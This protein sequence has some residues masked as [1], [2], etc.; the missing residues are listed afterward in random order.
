MP[1]LLDDI[2]TDFSRGMDDSRAATAFP[3]DAAKSIVNGRV[4]PDGTVG[5]RWG[6]RRLHTAALEDGIGYGGITF[7]TDAGVTQEIDIFG[8]KA[9]MSD[10]GWVTETEIASGL[11]EDYYTFTTMSVGGVTYLYLANGD[12]TIKRWDGSTWDTLP[13]VPE[14]VK[15]VETFNSR[16]Y[17]AGHSGVIVQASKVSDPEVW[18]TSLGAL[19]VQVQTHGGDA[20]TGIFQLG[21]YLIV[22]DEDATSYIDGF[23]EQTIV[24]AAGA[25][26]MSRSVG[27]IAHRT[28]QAIGDRGVCWLSKR[29]VE[30]LV[31]GS[32][33]R[34]LTRNMQTFMA[35]VAREQIAV[36]RGRPT[37]VYD[38]VTQDYVL[39][40]STTG[41][42][43]NRAV[44][45]N[46]LKEGRDWIGSPSTDRY[47]DAD[48]DI[49]L[50]GGAD[51]YLETSPTGSPTKADANGYMVL[52][53][54]GDAADALTEEDG[55]LAL[56]T[57]DTVPAT[58]YIAPDSVRGTA[59]HSLG[60]DGFVRKHFDA[61]ADDEIE[62]GTGGTPVT[63]TLVPRPFLF[64]RPRNKKRARIVHVA[65]I[66]EDPATI[67]VAIRAD[68]ELGAARSITIPGTSS[69]Q[70]KRRRA[71]VHGIDDAPE[72][73]LTTTDRTR[74]SLVGLS[75]EVMK[76]P[77]Q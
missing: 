54:A 42:R 41:N 59:I 38:H 5:R 73:V 47:L 61:D 11:R 6:S 27:C 20:I 65:A 33:I 25:T 52:A 70:A 74:I 12:T 45:V 28:I 60:Y 34:L 75:A 17:V 36:N 66:N 8:A 40:L 21:S 58:L 77:D 69:N 29:G 46:M 23:G 3:Q 7:Q 4:E 43:N 76:E 48:G 62:D 31:S 30:Y 24:V 13:N 16:L 50:A 10:D 18:S 2:A 44:V 64:R 26:G 9:F 32:G 49:L 37:A 51:G 56:S 57:N 35:S 22:W 72:V 39:T 63:L 15:F 55:Y 68:G 67:M 71:F 1:R 53:G 14:N 19:L